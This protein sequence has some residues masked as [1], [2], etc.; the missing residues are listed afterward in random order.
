M[1]DSP[2]STRLKDERAQWLGTQ[3]HG[4]TLF[5]LRTTIT[6]ACV[7]PLLI[8]PILRY[9][10]QRPNRILP[11]VV[12]YVACLVIGYLGSELAWRRGIRLTKEPSDTSC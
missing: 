5:M 12:S 2:N 10:L 4:K 7:L 11:I 9:S 6:F 3:K 8:Y 1:F